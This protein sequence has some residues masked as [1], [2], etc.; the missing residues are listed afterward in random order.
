MEKQIPM[1]ETVMTEREAF[2][3]MFSFQQPLGD[4]NASEDKA[5]ANADAFAAELVSKL[6]PVG[7]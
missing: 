7:R 1:F 3:A 4:L 6:Q 5:V 2:R